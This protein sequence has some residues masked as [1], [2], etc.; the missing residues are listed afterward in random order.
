MKRKVFFKIWLLCSVLL[1]VAMVVPGDSLTQGL[2]S[3]FTYQGKLTDSGSPANGVYDFQFELH[4]AANGEAQVGSTLIQN[5]IMVSEGLFTVQLDFGDVFLGSAMWLEISVR[6]GGSSGD[7]TALSPRQLLT[8]TPYALYSQET[9][10]HDHLGQSWVGDNNP[11]VIGGTF[12]GFPESDAALILNNESN[13]GAG[14]SVHSAGLGLFVE[15]TTRDGVQ[16]AMAGDDGVMV[17]TAGNSSPPVFSGE[18]NGFEIG[19]A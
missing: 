12:E 4:D 14:V 1:A 9:A 15:S 19:G 2:G 10:P 7:Y 5:D 17:Q 11:L 3:V 16:I 13:N 18:A 6:P 8:A